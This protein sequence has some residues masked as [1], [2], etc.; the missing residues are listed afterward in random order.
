MNVGNGVL[1]T[2]LTHC[3]RH[4]LEQHPVTLAYLYGSAAIG[5]MTPLSDI[6]IALVLDEDT[7][8]DFP[9]LQF[10]LM[11]ADR[12]D[13]EC[14]ISQADVRIVNDAPIMLRGRVVTEGISLFV[15]DEAKRI[16]FEARTRDEYFDFLP[17]ARELRRAFFL[18][19]SVRG[20]DGRRT[21]NRIDATQPQ[22]IRQLA[23]IS[24][25]SSPASS[26]L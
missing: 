3:L 21:E 7:V 19:V 23:K 13:E 5:R 22:A 6:D 2:A 10:E 24:I 11:V 16:A 20:I 9:R 26:H 25:D 15:R 4:V 8:S 18:D 14:G 12:I 1:I 17:V